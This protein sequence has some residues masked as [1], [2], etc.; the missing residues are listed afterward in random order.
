MLKI[1]V[2]IILSIIVLVATNSIL[3]S[4]PNPQQ[5]VRQRESG[6]LSE[7]KSTEQKTPSDIFVTNQQLIDAIGRAIEASANKAKAEQNPYPSDNSSWLFSLGLVLVG[8]LQCYIIFKTLKETQKAAN[9]A[10]KSADVAISTQRA[11]VLLKEINPL[12]V[13]DGQKT[14]VLQWQFTTSFENSGNT[15]A[16]NMLIQVK[17]KISETPEI[18]GPQEYKYGFDVAQTRKLAPRTI[19]RIQP[20]SVSADDITA[21]HNATR[22]LYIFGVIIYNDI[23]QEIPHTERFCEKIGIIGNPSDLTTEPQVTFTSQSVPDNDP[24]RN[25]RT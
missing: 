22:H 21:I 12:R 14:K 10:K 13:T 3:W 5:P 4:E 16:I 18:P 8:G 7:E 1:K 23:M 11:Y 20:V 19:I 15:P 24:K 25:E 6:N 17:L 2:I 9:A